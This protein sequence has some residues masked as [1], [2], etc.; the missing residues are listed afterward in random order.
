MGIE[1]I[2]IISN[3]LPALANKCVKVV[4]SDD[5]VSNKKKVSHLQMIS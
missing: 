1:T 2:Q 5:K 4:K 3:Y